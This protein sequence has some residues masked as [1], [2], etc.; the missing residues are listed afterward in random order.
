MRFWFLM[1][2]PAVVQLVKRAVI[3]AM[4]RSVV[5]Q[6]KQ[7]ECLQAVRQIAIVLMIAI[8]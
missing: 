2:I 3:V 7:M 1:E 5:V 4:V 6:P 8:L